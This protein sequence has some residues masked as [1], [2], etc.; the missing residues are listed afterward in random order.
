MSNRDVLLGIHNSSKL[1]SLSN[2]AKM[3]KIL[4]KISTYMVI[5][6]NY[7]SLSV[8][9][10]GMFTPSSPDRKW[11]STVRTMGVFDTSSMAILMYFRSMADWTYLDW[12]NLSSRRISFWP[13]F[14]LLKCEIHIPLLTCISLNITSEIANLI[15][16]TA[17]WQNI[18][19]FGH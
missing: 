5:S 10:N 8:G 3:P 16:N 2:N 1:K 19:V 12:V 9:G 13:D 15:K 7:Q 17:L 18:H 4:T 6:T 14:P 11:T